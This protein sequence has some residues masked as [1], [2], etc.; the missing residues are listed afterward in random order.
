MNWLVSL[1]L[2][3][4]LLNQCILSFSTSL[5]N[6]FACSSTTREILDQDIYG[7]SE[8]NVVT[9]CSRSTGVI[10]RTGD[11]GYSHSVASAK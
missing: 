3:Q 8:P 9:L 7:C 6:L 11:H 10:S 1:D 2:P 4:L 5:N